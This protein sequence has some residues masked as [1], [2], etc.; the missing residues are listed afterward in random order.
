M[1][2]PKTNRE[3]FGKPFLDEWFRWEEIENSFWER[4]VDTDYVVDAL[5]SIKTAGGIY[6]F[7]WSKRPPR[8][9]HP[10][11]EAIRYIGE[12][13]NF[14]NRMDQFGASAGFWGTPYS[15]HS[16]GWR[17]PLGQKDNLF[18]AFYP[19]HKQQAHIFKGFRAWYEAQALEIYRKQN[20]EI[21]LLNQRN[22]G[23]V[24]F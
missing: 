24:N 5:K 3:F 22:N 18:I 2:W 23:R 6:L 13:S 16:A 19:F 11:A 8:L 10:K 14:K 17:W 1:E 20:G 15:G 7:A 9:R 4:G 21:P 12:T